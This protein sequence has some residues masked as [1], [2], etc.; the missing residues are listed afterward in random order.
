M[1]K[2]VELFEEVASYKNTLYKRILT[3]KQVQGI[4]KTAVITFDTPNCILF[5]T[6]HEK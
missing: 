5:Q 1:G 4:I 6:I 2:N 3:S